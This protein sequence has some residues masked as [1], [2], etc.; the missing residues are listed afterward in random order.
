MPEGIATI[1]SEVFGYI[2]TF[3]HEDFMQLR[4]T[5]V[6]STV[7]WMF[8][9]ASNSRWF[10]SAPNDGQKREGETPATVLSLHNSEPSLQYDCHTMLPMG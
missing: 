6:R 9:Y 8:E 3:S 7:G 10:I 1:E 2:V 5:K 4:N